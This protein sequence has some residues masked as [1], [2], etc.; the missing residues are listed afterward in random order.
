MSLQGAPTRTIGQLYRDCLRLVKHVAA[1]SAKGDKLRA[2]VGGEFRKNSHVTDDATI[3][4]LKGNAVRALSNYL[5]IESL[6]KDDKFRNTAAAFNTRQL[7]AVETEFEEEDDED[8]ANA[9]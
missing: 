6:S 1:N 7:N 5:M 4:A 8:A 2:I 3:H 9:K